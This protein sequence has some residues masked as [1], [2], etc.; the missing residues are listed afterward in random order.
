MA[1][2]DSYEDIVITDTSGFATVVC[3]SNTA[4]LKGQTAAKAQNGLY[5]FDDFKMFS[6]MVSHTKR[7]LVSHHLELVE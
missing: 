6:R 3:D 4:I 1:L 5:V 7:K 2:F